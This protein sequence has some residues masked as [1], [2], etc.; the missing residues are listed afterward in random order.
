MLERDG[1]DVVYANATTFGDPLRAGRLFMDMHPSTGAGLDRVARQP[2][3]QRDGVGAGAT[4]RARVGRSVR[5]V[6]AELRRLRHVAAGGSWRRPHRPSP[7]PARTKPAPAGE[8][9]GQMAS[10]CVSTSCVCSTRRRA[11]CLTL[12]SAGADRRPRRAEFSALLRLHEGRR[13]FFAGDFHRAVTALTEANP[14]CAVRNCDSRWS[15]CAS[16]RAFYSGP[17]TS[18]IA[19]SSGPRRDD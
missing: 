18:A 15:V 2:A 3:V 19:S 5:R 16:S 11:S 14:T 12:T 17:T 13:R 7:A 8:P 4:R 6:V 9:V 1:L 10:R